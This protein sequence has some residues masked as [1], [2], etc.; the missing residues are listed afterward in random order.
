MSINDD[1]HV[2][3]LVPDPSIVTTAESQLDRLPGES[4]E[5]FRERERAYKLFRTAIKQD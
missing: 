3:V 2:V 5:A 1:G 4:D